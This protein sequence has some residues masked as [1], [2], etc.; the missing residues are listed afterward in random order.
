MSFSN[1]RG[2]TLIELLVTI[3]IIAILTALLSVNFISARERGRDG[4]RKSNVLQMQS[5]MELMRSDT[6][7]Y[8]SEE[9]MMDCGVPLQPSGQD[10]VYMSKIPCDPSADDAAY[11]YTANPSGCNNEEGN[12]CTYYMLFACL[13]NEDDKDAL[14]RDEYPVETHGCE[15]VN[16]VPFMVTT[17]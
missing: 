6:G 14:E 11:K 4:Q 7:Y 5:A 15:N 12:T 10:T 8:P 1:G 2:F 13:E 3:S 17:P 9:D 16:T